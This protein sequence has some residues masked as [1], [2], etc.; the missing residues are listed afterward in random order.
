[1][2][3]QAKTTKQNTYFMYLF[4]SGSR[5]VGQRDVHPP[6]RASFPPRP[7]QRHA[8]LPIGARFRSTATC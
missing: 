8:A 3:A 2:K 1:M 7:G 5:D 6:G 4:L